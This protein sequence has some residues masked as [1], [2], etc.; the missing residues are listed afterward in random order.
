MDVEAQ[1]RKWGG[2]WWGE[3]DGLEDGGCMDT[4]K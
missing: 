3:Y 2:L 1:A 4:A